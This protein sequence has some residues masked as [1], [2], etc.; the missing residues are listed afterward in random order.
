MR[1]IRVTADMEP[2]LEIRDLRTSFSTNQGIVRAVDGVSLSI[3]RGEA[4]G[5][6]GESG[7]GKSQLFMSALGLTAP[8]GRV[9]GSA[10]FDGME[11]IGAPAAQLNAIRGRRIAVVFQNPMTSLN[12]YLRISTQM[13]EVLKLH[14]GMSESEARVRA[15]ELLD[16]VQ[17]PAARD[18]V[19][20]Y[21][22]EFSGGMRQRVMIAMGLLCEPELL[23][24][25]EP[26][27]ALDVTVQAQILDLLTSLRRELS[28]ALVLITHNLGVV[29]GFVDRVAVM[30][31]GRVVEEA[32]VD[33]LFA[34]PRHPYS[35]A[36]LRSTPDLDDDLAEEIPSI[37]GQPPNLLEEAAGCRFAER[38]PA[39]LDA[40]HDLD[41]PLLAAGQARHRAACLLYEGEAA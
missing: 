32:A 24:A 1:S 39:V 37:P 3:Q 27:T 2:L 30:Y 31:A 20:L 12:P 18:R 6:V 26:T 25:D 4:F 8:N 5:I 19:D 10:R 38:C 28:M 21:P 7:S 11:M 41:P 35:A 40:C 22:H 33:E 14:R 23:I 34:Q 36:L 9:T 15:I 16:N 29:A 17:I 13:V